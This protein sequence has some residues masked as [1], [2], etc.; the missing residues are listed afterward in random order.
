LWSSAVF[1]ERPSTGFSAA[2]ILFGIGSIAGPALVGAAA[3]E[4]G[5]GETFLF[6]AALAV[7]TALVRPASEGAA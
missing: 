5:L 3:D 1:R 4:Y 6:V 7:L 2:L